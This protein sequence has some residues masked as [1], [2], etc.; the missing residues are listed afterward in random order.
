[1]REESTPQ[2]SRKDGRPPVSALAKVSAA[3]A[4]GTSLTMILPIF[5]LGGSPDVVSIT[6][7]AVGIVFATL[8]FIGLRWAPVLPTLY[9]LAL[10]GMFAG[11]LLPDLK[12]PA[13]PTFPYE[14]AMLLLPVCGIPA[15][16]AG[17]VQHYRGGA[18]VKPAWLGGALIA[19]VSLYVGAVA[20]SRVPVVDA[21]A[22]VSPDLLTEL[23]LMKLENFQFSQEELRVKA[24][25]LVVLRLENH[26][27]A[28]HLFE[29]D[30]LNLH[31]PV[32]PGKS[33]VAVFRAPKAGTY[34]IYCTPHYDKTQHQGMHATLVV[35]D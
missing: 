31:V 13:T 26:D 24:G 27:P 8:V 15:G 34:M 1:M 20:V 33:S 21:G 5:T 30:E 28:L 35:T 9:C 7:A 12:V 23:P 25:E 16:I 22:G 18:M 32:I 6:I 10:L 29:V 3:M 11:H 14:L 2:P 17:T 19:L 4:A